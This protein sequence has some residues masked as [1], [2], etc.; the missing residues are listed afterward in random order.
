MINRSQTVVINGEKSKEA[1]VRSGVPQGAVLGPLLFLLYINDIGD[2][3]TSRMCLFVDYS[4]TVGIVKSTIDAL[5][6]QTN[7]HKLNA[8]A[9]RW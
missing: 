8:W 9:D 7:L 2:G 3:L 4:I 1:L 5:Q 6:I